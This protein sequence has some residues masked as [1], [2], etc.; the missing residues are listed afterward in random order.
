MPVARGLANRFRPDLAEAGIGR[1]WHGFR[2]VL[3][4]ALDPSRRHRVAVR[5]E[6]DGA[7]LPGSPLLLPAL[8]QRAPL[9]GSGRLVR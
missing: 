8:P 5:R 7:E 9:R 4:H 6:A 3:P 1:G 2:V